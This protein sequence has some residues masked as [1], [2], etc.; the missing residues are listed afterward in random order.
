MRKWFTIPP[1][2]QLI[3]TIGIMGF[4]L[5][6]AGISSS[7]MILRELQQQ[8]LKQVNAQLAQ[9]LQVAMQ[10]NQINKDSYVNGILDLHSQSVRER[11]FVNVFKSFPDA[12]MSFIGLADGSFYGARRTAEGELQVVRNNKETEGASQYFR[13]DS[14]GE[15]IEWVNDFPNFDP[16]KRPWFAKAVEVGSPVFSNVYSHFVFREPTITASLPVYDKEDQLIGVFGVDYLLS[17]LA[18]ELGNLPIGASGQ[19]FVTDDAGL[20]VATSLDTPSYRMVDGTSQLIPARD[21]SNTLIQASLSL[22]E[23]EY[24][25][26]LPEFTVDGHR[27]YV[28]R[29]NFREYGFN[30]NIHVLSAEDDFLGSVKNATTKSTIIMVLSLLFS[31]FFTSWIAGRV[32][33]PI[34]KISKAAEALANGKHIPIPDDGRGDELGVL[35]RSF[36]KMGYQLTH[37]VAQLEEEVRMRTHELQER[38]GELQALSFMDSLTGISNRRQFDMTLKNA[39]NLALRHKRNIALFMLDIDLFKSFNDT[40]GHQ[41]GDDCLKAVGNVLSGKIRRTSDLVARYGGEEFVIL[42]QE[43]EIE[44]LEDYAQDI[45]KSV[46]GLQIKHESSPFGVVTVCVGVAHMIPSVQTT[47]ARLI[48]MADHAMY[49]AKENG[50]NQVVLHRE[51]LKC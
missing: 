38:N 14:S 29:L 42:L 9:Q 36:N 5:I 34:V 46:E 18:D 12:A 7:H 31:V 45:R 20:L 44:K 8:M 39:W 10:L 11:Y 22:P 51:G 47:S 25:K 30:W 49:Q 40:H 33:K 27:Y 43:E 3:L 16:R 1:L 21:I 15:G 48:E 6:Q 50:R 4:F 35:T 28:G 37:M 13:T 41:A 19:V 32:T 17:W 2:L 24:E 26:E 23:G